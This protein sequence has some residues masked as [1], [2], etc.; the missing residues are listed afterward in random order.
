MSSNSNTKL[1]ALVVDDNKI[2]RN[3]E[4]KLLTKLG[5]EACE[6]YNGKE[7]VDL[8]RD[9]NEFDLIL[10]DLNM[11]VMNGLEATRL[12]REMGVTTRII[13]LSSQA[14][15]YVREVFME[16]GVDDFVEKPLS[17]TKLASILTK[18]FKN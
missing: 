10:M 3:I 11:P 4:V 7:A 18:Y 5:V 17:H 16:A 14:S 1:I 9:E 8:L 15:E 13:G 2:M 6:V 12:L